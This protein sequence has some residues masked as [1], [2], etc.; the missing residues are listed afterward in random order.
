LIKPLVYGYLFSFLGEKESTSKELGLRLGQGSEF[1]LL[2]S[3]TAVTSG[4]I[5]ERTDSL[6]S[7]I[8][9]ASFMVSTYFV[10]ANYSTPISV[11]AKTRRD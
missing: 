3:A 10:M 1:A 5:S 2:L 9:I 6:I 7:F 11:E 4:V 8:V